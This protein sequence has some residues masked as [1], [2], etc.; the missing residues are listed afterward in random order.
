M[1][2]IKKWE[3]VGLQCFKY[4]YRFTQ[5]TTLPAKQKRQNKQRKAKE[6]L[7]QSTNCYKIYC[8]VEHSRAR[9][10]KKVDIE[11]IPKLEEFSNERLI[12]SV[13][14]IFRI[15]LGDFFPRKKRHKGHQCV[16][17]RK[18]HKD[19]YSGPMPREKAFGIQEGN[20]YKQTSNPQREQ[21]HQHAVPTDVGA[22]GDLYAYGQA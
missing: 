4:K 18:Y 8:G 12:S 9:Y 6:E 19:P 11:H 10:F 21:H 15:G 5:G 14:L 22:K 16:Q 7:K 2:S 1:A 3:A 17:H 13:R 20:I